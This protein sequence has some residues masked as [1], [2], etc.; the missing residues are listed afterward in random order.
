MYRR[1]KDAVPGVNAVHLAQS[2]AAMH[3]YISMKK[4]VD[5]DPKAAAL[6]LA[7]VG[8]VKL[9]VVVDDDI[10]VFHDEQV[11][12]AIAVRFQAHDIDIIRGLKGSII[13]PSNTHPTAHS[14]AIIDAT[15]PKSRPFPTRLKVPDDVMKRIDLEDYVP[16]RIRELA[17]RR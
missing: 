11:L 5:G 8:F 7:S 12:W 4:R 16:S 9:I 13:D 6:A 2:G 3:A 10:D 1:A 15:E 17:G 14:L